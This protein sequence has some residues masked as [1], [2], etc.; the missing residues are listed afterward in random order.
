MGMYESFAQVYDAFMDNV[1]YEEWSARLIGMLK[2]HGINDGLLLDLGCG[3][4]T[5]TE[6]LAAAGYDMI[7]AD[8][9][10]EML[11]I[12]IEKKERSGLDILYLQQDMRSF[13]LY[14]TVRA[15]VSICDSIN[16]ITENRELLE[17]FR[18]VNN[19]LDPG[20]LFLF[21]LNTVY[22]YE[23]ILG[24]QTFAENRE[25][26]SLIWE[27]TYWEEERINEY[28]LTLFLRQENGFYR[29]FH[30]THY[31]KAYSLEEIC[32]LLEEAGLI[33]ERVIDADTMEKPGK[34]TER[35]LFLAREHGK[36]C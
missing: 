12:A 6:A 22:K 17:V 8:L 27:N 4:G 25:E 21:D 3:T 19:Y 7:G 5:V 36:A 20:G 1:P 30:E 10:G 31:Q 16:Y 13:E 18:L 23:N 29:R 28:D 26:C 35:L 15:V 34:E 9:S 2:E 24:D 14:G 33:L 11:R 32:S